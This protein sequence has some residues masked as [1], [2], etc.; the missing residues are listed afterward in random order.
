VNALN[1]E[2]N[3]GLKE[4]INHPLCTKEEALPGFKCNG[5]NSD[6]H[7]CD[8]EVFVTKTIKWESPYIL[9]HIH[10]YKTEG[11]RMLRADNSVSTDTYKEVKCHTRV[12]IP[13]ELLASDF[14]EIGEDTKYQLTGAIIHEGQN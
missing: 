14:A 13:T 9:F 1:S 4:I 11:G 12:D 5:D 6:N 10:R 3:I 8:S 2:D 7:Q